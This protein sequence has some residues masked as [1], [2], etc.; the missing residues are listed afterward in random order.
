MGEHHFVGL[1][2][3]TN[4]VPHWVLAVQAG[5]QPAELDYSC[6][7]VACLAFRAVATACAERYWLDGAC[8]IISLIPPAPFIADLVASLASVNFAGLLISGVDPQ[9][10]G[11]S[12]AEVL[13]LK[14]T[15][16]RSARLCKSWTIS[17][18]LRE[19]K[20]LLAA[21]PDVEELAAAH[22]GQD[23]LPVVPTAMVEAGNRRADNEV[24]R[25]DGCSAY[26]CQLRQCASCR[27]RA[28]CSRECQ[29]QA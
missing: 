17:S 4:V 8:T 11:F 14:A 27:Q 7:S 6:R 26:F 10:G 15:V 28:Y 1:L 12:L 3:C 18:G 16:K 21:L 2:A 23:W 13:Q 19:I 29:L 5:A 24:L 22:P 20:R 25:G 9:R